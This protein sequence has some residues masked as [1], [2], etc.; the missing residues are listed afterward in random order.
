MTLVRDL[1]AED[2]LW[3]PQEMSLL[4]AAR[5]LSE[6]QVGA[7]PVCSPDGKVVGVLSKTDLADLFGP[8]SEGRMVRDA[9]NVE[10]LS[11]TADSPI[12]DAI[13]EMVFEG[14]H[15]LI[16]LDVNGRLAGIVSAMDVLRHLSGFPRRDQPVIA[17]APPVERPA[18]GVTPFQRVLVPTD[19]S[20]GSRRALD[21]AIDLAQRFDASIVLMH[22][23]E[24][25]ADGLDEPLYSTVLDAVEL[26]E[27]LAAIRTRWPRSEARLTSGTP[28]RQILRAVDETKADLIVIGT[29]G[30]HG[31]RRVLLGSVAERVVRVAPIPVLTVRARD[32]KPTERFAPQ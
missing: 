14:V 10:V 13:R 28:W 30:H 5:A 9:M 29:E 2:V 7:A 8:A 11:A 32:A 3:F 21:V 22:A 16:V 20:E 27:V 17:V 26:E 18:T 4:D 12:E 1:M 25:P 19:F 6:R 31:L 15:H 23:C 24:P